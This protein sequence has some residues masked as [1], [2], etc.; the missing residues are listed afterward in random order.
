[1]D[2][3]ASKQKNTDKDVP[4]DLVK[5][6]NDRINRI[7]EFVKLESKVSNLTNRLDKMQSIID[8]LSRANRKL[9]NNLDTVTAIIRSKK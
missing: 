9:A 3:Y 4:N 6:V 2:I 1:M 8:Q 5:K 7:D